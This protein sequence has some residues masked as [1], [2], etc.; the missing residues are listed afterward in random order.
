LIQFRCFYTNWIIAKTLVS[1]A[2]FGTLDQ[3]LNYGPWAREKFFACVVKLILKGGGIL[4]LHFAMEE[5]NVKL[6]LD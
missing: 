5:Q 3:G 1:Q 4:T 2:I 6:K